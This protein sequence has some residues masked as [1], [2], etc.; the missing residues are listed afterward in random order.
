MSRRFRFAGVFVMVVLASAVAAMPGSS[1]RA[2]A[3][4]QSSS[5]QAIAYASRLTDENKVPVKD[6]A[7]DFMFDWTYANR[8]MRTATINT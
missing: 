1:T 7:Y 8:R 4:G 6:G 3:P 5:P 2:M